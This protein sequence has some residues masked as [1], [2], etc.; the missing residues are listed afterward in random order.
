MDLMIHS[1][2]IETVEGG[3][4]MDVTAEDLHVKAYVVISATDFTVV[5]KLIPTSVFESGV[6]VH[7]AG[8][9]Q[10]CDITEQVVQILENM[11]PDDVVAY[12]CDGAISY[13]ETL[14]VLGIKH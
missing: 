8:V 6:Q 4:L 10:S 7:V 9:D 1:K 12:L 13:G 14:A 5:E 2:V 11:Q 3:V